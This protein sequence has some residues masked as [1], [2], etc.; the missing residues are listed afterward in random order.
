M[1]DLIPPEI[2]LHVFRYL[3]GPAPSEMRLHDQPSL[4]L[5]TTKPGY[6]KPLKT[7]SLV[8]RPWRSLV[9]PSLFRHI[10][11]KP[12]VYSLS[13]FTLN[14]IP[15]LRFIVENRLARSA[16]TFTLVIDFD[17][18][19]AKDYQVTPQIRTVDLEWL[20]DQLFSVIDPLRFTI[21]ARPTTLAALLSRMLFLD[22]AWTFD[23][24]YHILSLARTIRGNTI[25]AYSGGVEHS[26]SSEAQLSSSSA[27][28]SLG[29]QLITQARSFASQHPSA[30]RSRAAPP[31]PLFTIRPWTSLLLNEGSSTKVYRMYEF[32]LRRPPSM[33]GAL[34]GCEEHPNDTPLIPQTVIDFNYIAIFPLSSHFEILL[35]HL[36]RL[37]RLF[38][39]LT[40][41]PRNSILEN[42][43][44]MKYIAPADLWMERNTSYSL[45]MRQLIFDTSS[46]TNWAQ[47]RV[48]E[49]GDAETD[50]EAWGMAIQFLESSGVKEWKAERE[51]VLA[52]HVDDEQFPNWRDQVNGHV[53]GLANTP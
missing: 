9:L 47:L 24:P 37:D 27:S 48:F 4:D 43:N 19:V 20:W 50:R 35:Q 8:S 6:T 40:P 17:D 36:P 45:L 30:V 22:D 1:M 49:S 11:W 5:L 39:Q 38:V 13:A 31:C 2:L 29:S 46:Q 53:G 42:E 7:A 51:G 15:L 32:F 52:K 23:I 25:K 18:P 34:L 3:D 14:P 12:N 21:L 41:K 28:P 16:I 26:M 33:L 10:L 44:E